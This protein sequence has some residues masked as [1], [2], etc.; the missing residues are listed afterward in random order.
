MSHS[1]AFLAMASFSHIFIGAADLQKSVA[2]TTPLWVLLGIKNL[3]SFSTT[4]W[5][6]FRFAKSRLSSSPPGNGERLPATA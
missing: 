2:S 6:I 1:C 3:R 5:G 4:D